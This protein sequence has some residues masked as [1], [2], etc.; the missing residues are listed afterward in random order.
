MNRTANCPTPCFNQFCWYLINTSHT[1]CKIVRY[2][3]WC[4]VSIDSFTKSPR[5]TSFS[6]M[7]LFTNKTFRTKCKTTWSNHAQSSI[8]QDILVLLKRQCTHSPRIIRTASTAPRLVKK[9]PTF[10]FTGLTTAHQWSLSWT[11]MFQY[12]PSNLT[13]LKSF[14][15]YPFSYSQVFQ[16]VSFHQV[17]LTENLYAYLSCPRHA[18][19][20]TSSSPLTESFSY[21][22]RCTNNKQKNVGVQLED[23]IQT[24][25]KAKWCC[26]YNRKLM[27]SYWKMSDASFESLFYT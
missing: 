22:T 6:C 7:S 2:D 26:K 1:Q 10:F 8:A 11:R 13:S 15:I 18:T 9:F 21:L 27:W 5:H 4:T 20:I 16:V 19:S 23:I 14:L 25:I 24:G 17:F 12:T 3:S